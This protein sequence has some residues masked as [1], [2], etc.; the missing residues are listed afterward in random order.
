[1]NLFAVAAI[2]CAMFVAETA[3]LFAEASINRECTDGDGA[4]CTLTFDGEILEG[5]AARIRMAIL[6]SPHV[7]EMIAFNSPGGDPFEALKI[8][9]VLNRYVVEFATGDCLGGDH[10]CLAMTA[11]DSCA[12]ACSLIYLIANDR[13]G[14]EIFLHRPTFSASVFRRMTASQAEAAYNKKTQQLLA[15]LRARGVP[16]SE[17]ELI[18]GIPSSGVEKL[19]QDYPQKSPWMAEWLT[20][21]CGSLYRAPDPNSANALDFLNIDEVN[22]EVKAITTEQKHAQNKG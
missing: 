14:T 21:R 17:I 19:S 22:C 5:D 4:E 16:E 18:M 12:S 2:G 11:G 15:G 10:P 20:A 9:D 7:V 3:P 6:E 13:F 1:M 8:A